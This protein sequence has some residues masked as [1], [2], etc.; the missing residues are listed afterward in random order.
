LR[1]LN[2]KLHAGPEGPR[3]CLDCGPGG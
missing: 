1:D 2:A 3:R